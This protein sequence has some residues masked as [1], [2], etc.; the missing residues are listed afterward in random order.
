MKVGGSSGQSLIEV[1]VAIGVMSLLLVALLVTV[2]LSIKNSRLAKDRNQA[3]ALAQEGVE[4]IRAYRDYDYAE[5][6]SKDSLVAYDLPYNWVVE[7]G[8]G[9][10]CSA[11]DFAIRD[12]FRR[13][14]L[15]TRVDATSTDVQV[16]VEWQEGSRTHEV[17][18]ITRLSQ[19]ER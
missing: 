7:D 12:F 4:L 5:F 19:W 16:T 3:V 1:V 9:D 2:S 6:Y 17:F 11:T 15:V 14:V 18:Q 10:S 13:C 8:L